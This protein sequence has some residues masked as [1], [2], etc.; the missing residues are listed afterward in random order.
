MFRKQSWHLQWENNRDTRAP[1]LEPGVALLNDEYFN[2]LFDTTSVRLH[3]VKLTARLREAEEYYSR[4]AIGHSTRQS[5]ED[6]SRKRW[7]RD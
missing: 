7:M 2:F 5:W 4:I 3:S 1:G 6:N